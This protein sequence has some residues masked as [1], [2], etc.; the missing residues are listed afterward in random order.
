VK[1]IKAYASNIAQDILSFKVAAT[2]AIAIN[3]CLIVLR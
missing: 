2:V 1:E 3:I